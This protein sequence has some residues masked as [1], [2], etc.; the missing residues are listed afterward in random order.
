MAAVLSVEEIWVGF[1]DG[2]EG[3]CVVVNQ[4][5]PTQQILSIGMWTALNAGMH[6]TKRGA[7][8]ISDAHG[9]TPQATPEQV[10]GLN[11]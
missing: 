6:L 4:G 8:L 5:K 7:S 10:K 9:G 2:V 11:S 1:M 3:V